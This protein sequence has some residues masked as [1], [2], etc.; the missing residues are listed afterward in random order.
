VRASTP[1]A[2][3]SQH[4]LRLIEVQRCRQDLVPDFLSRSG[5]VKKPIARIRQRRGAGD[6]KNAAMTP[7][8]RRTNQ[9]E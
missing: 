4:G 5:G 6:Q 7:A 1:E 8:R 2:R 3:H 9:R